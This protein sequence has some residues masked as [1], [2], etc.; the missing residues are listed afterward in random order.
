MHRLLLAA[1][2]LV[3]S[4]AYSQTV[5]K[6]KGVDGKPVYQS[7]PCGG[8]IPPEKTW[9]GSYRQPTNDELWQ[10]YRTNERWQQQQA[11]NR[12]R[13]SAARSYSIQ[14]SN[15]SKS[16]SYA[17]ACSAS[18]SEYKRVQS[19]FTL[20]RNIDLLRKLEADMYRYCEAR[21]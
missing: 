18:R 16:A 1:A 20:N 9:G 11:A 12:A 2:L 13:R 14:P 4:V 19:D 10:R 7:F 17:A 3:P 8:A 5:Y 21:P 6:C 15:T